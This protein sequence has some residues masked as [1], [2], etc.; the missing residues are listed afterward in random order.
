VN[1]TDVTV[2]RVYLMEHE[3]LDRLVRHLHDQTGVRGVT[4]F[5]GIGG[6]GAS[7]KTHGLGLVDLSLDLPVVVEFFDDPARAEAVVAGLKAL[8][9][10]RH[11]L[12]WPASVC[13]GDRC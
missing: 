13:E 1:A 12:L 10:P 3:G 7:R 4:V 11:I 8:V 9:D 2:V 5:R 6:F